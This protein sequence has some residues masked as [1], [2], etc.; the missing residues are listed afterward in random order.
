MYFILIIVNGRLQSQAALPLVSFVQET[1]WGPEPV[2]TLTLT[3]DNAVT[4]L[5]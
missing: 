2:G 3:A 1:G 4:I 5:T